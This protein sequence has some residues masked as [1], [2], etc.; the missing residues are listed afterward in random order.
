M[1]DICSKNDCTGCKLCS[2]VCPKKCISFKKD[3]LGVEYPVIDKEK[4]ISCH[5][6]EKNCPSKHEFEYKFPRTAYAAW[7]SDD[8]IRNSSTSGGI[9]QELYNYA[10]VNNYS[11]YGVTLEKNKNSINDTYI[12]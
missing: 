8:E 11:T 1:M 2:N 10:L 5:L 7:S 6:C 9:A 4:C 12:Y 3:E